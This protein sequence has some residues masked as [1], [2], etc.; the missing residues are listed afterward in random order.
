MAKIKNS[1]DTSNDFDKFLIDCPQLIKIDEKLMSDISLRKFDIELNYDIS[2]D[3]NGLD[4][5]DCVEFLMELERVLDISIP[6]DIAGCL[7]NTN[8]KPPRSMQYLR[9]K[10]LEDLGL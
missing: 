9:N 6:D 1:S 4:D 8:K 5:L 3:D 7:F 2:F 10:K